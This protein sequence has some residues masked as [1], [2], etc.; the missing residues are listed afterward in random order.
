MA[1][2]I[3][4]RDMRWCCNM[5]RHMYVMHLTIG[6]DYLGRNEPARERLDSRGFAGTECY[7]MIFFPSAQWP[8]IDVN[9]SCMYPLNGAAP[10]SSRSM[11]HFH[12]AIRALG[13]GVSRSNREQLSFLAA[14][15]NRASR[16]ARAR[17]TNNF[18]QTSAS[19]MH[20][21]ARRVWHDAIWPVCM[22]ALWWALC[23]PP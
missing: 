3:C 15:A 2:A 12:Y 7:A 6:Y 11:M 17:R 18:L 14:Y 22:W 23:A 21:A 20:D 8:E 5:Y 16:R 4:M 9:A 19:F 1:N 10:P 13:R